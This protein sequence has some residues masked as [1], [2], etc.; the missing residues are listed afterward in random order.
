[1]SLSA[2]SFRQGMRQLAAAVCVV[3][4]QREAAGHGHAFAETAAATG[5][6]EDGARNGL[7]A[8]AVMSV[9]ADPPRLAVSVNRSAS[10]FHVLAG[11][12]SFAVNVLRYDQVKI[13][14]RFAGLDGVKGAARFANGEWITLSTGSPVLADSAASFDCRLESRI[15]VGT[16]ALLIGAV[17]AARVNPSERPLL[18]LD[19]TWASLVKANAADIENYRQTV[20]LCIAAVDQAARGGCDHRERLRRFV[21]EFTAINIAQTGITRDFLYRE[22]YVE[23]EKLAE[24]NAAKNL[25]DTKLRQL[26]EDGI[27]DGAFKVEDARLTAL[28]ITGMISWMHR[29]Y[30]HEGRL[31]PGEVAVRL[32]NLVGEMVSADAPST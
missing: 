3:T 10:A 8:T 32:A 21:E 7:T 14:G 29:W 30:R 2:E 12:G 5:A 15:D 22:S 20:E 25:F 31:A 23:P 9:T 28:A 1:M 11:A 27:D 17:E 18:Y 26:I 6:E 19:G 24:I 16:H 4:A 13:A